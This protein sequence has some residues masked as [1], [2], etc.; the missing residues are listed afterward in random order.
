[1]GSIDTAARKMTSDSLIIDKY[2][3]IDIDLEKKIYIIY[4]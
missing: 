3:N 4:A 1:M 2:L